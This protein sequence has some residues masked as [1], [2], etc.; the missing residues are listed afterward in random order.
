MSEEWSARLRAEHGDATRRHQRSIA[1]HEAILRLLRAVE[2]QMMTQA[3]A[4]RQLEEGAA[5]LHEPGIVATYR[6][7][8]E[9]LCRRQE[10]TG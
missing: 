2:R 10:G 1:A 9:R 6:Q 8:I 7:T 4:I 3:Q 5:L